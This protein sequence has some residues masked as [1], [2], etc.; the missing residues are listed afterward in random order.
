M[1]VLGKLSTQIWKVQGDPN[2][3]A[4]IQTLINVGTASPFSAQ[5]IGELD[6]IYLDST[7]IRSLRAKETTLNAFVSDIGSPVDALITEQIAGM[8]EDTLAAAAS[9]VEPIAKRYML[10]LD[11]TIYVYSYF[12]ASQ[13]SAW[14]TFTPTYR[15]QAF[16]EGDEPTDANTEHTFRIDKMLTYKSRLY[17][18]DTEGNMYIFGG[19]TGRQYDCTQCEV[20]LPW[21]DDGNPQMHKDAFGVQAALKGQWTIYGGTD[22]RA[23]LTDEAIG[24]F[25]GANDSQ[26]D[27]T[28]DTGHIALVGGGT[29]FKVKLVSAQEAVRAVVSGITFD[30]NKGNVP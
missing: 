4:L 24:T 8:D 19:A 17:V 3:F 16:N 7:G 11:G 21:L 22:Q 25:G 15:L 1:A 5:S 30:Y 12:P 26:Q 29:H 9:G 28:F 14:S 27:S 13:I 18:R 6:V 20:E 2:E 10:Y 23:G